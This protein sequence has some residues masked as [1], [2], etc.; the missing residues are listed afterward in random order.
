MF[1]GVRVRIALRYTGVSAFSCQH[2]SE[3]S[4]LELVGYFASFSITPSARGEA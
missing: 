2:I 3:A 1:R 4:E